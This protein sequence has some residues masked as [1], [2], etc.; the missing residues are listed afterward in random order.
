MS[1]DVEWRLSCRFDEYVWMSYSLSS[2]VDGFT[3]R[4]NSIVGVLSLL[5]DLD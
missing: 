3:F 2:I 4:L 1:I 5:F